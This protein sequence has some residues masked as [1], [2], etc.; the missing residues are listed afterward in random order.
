MI[1]KRQFVMGLL[2]PLLAIQ[3][4]CH[5]KQAGLKPKLPGPAEAPTITQTLP[6]E[7]QAE[8]VPKNPEE[9]SADQQPPPVPKKKL[10]K[11]AKTSQP[12]AQTTAPQTPAPTTTADLRPPENPADA[13]AAVAIGPDI[14]SAEAVRDRQSTTKLIDSTENQLRRVDSNNLSSDQQAMLSQIRTFISQSRKA[15]TEGDYERA[16]NLAKKAQLLTDELMKK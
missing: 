3:L 12:P 10:R 7:I 4:A 15:I 14:S 13:A 1:S 16:S 5:K 6:Y 8:P 9:T 11:K 2:V